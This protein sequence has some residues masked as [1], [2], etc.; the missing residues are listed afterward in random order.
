MLQ[1]HVGLG[2]VVDDALEDVLLRR[3]RVAVGVSG[4]VGP[5][6]DLWALVLDTHD[7]LTLVAAVREDLEGEVV[8]CAVR[9]TEVEGLDAEDLDERR[10]DPLEL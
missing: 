8:D 7:M 9:G 3:D 4:V 2:V 1:H 6:E 5:E 10:L